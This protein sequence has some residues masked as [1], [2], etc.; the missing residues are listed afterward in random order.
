MP[1]IGQMVSVSYNAVLA[2]Q[3]KPANQW[4]ESALMR[5]FESGG[6]IKRMDFGPQI[7]APLDYQR[8]PG[9][10]ITTVDLQPLSNT[11]TET[12]T[13]ALYTPAEVVIPITYSD[14]D[15]VQN[16][17]SNQKVAKA[18]ALITNALDS[19]D[20][21]VE[22]YLFPAS[23]NGFLGFLTHIT[24]AGTGSSG[25]ISATT[26]A[27]WRNQQATYIDDTDIEAAFTTVYNSC[28][29]G[30]GSKTQPT[31]MVSDSPTHATFVGTQ[32]ALQ[33]WGA[34]DKLNAGFSGGIKFMNADYIFSQY[35]G[36]SVQFLNPKSFQ[37]CVSKGHFRELNEQIP[38]ENATGYTRRVYSALQTVVSNRSR[39]G[40]A[41][42]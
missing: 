39:L 24:L 41:H 13:S 19:H 8:N 1:T 10:V 40:V 34:G 42:L 23:T 27:F 35:G 20:D 12:I 15:E 7:E 29:K 31:L 26:D 5:A 30:S 11:K 9:S 6:F 3:R 33:R 2:D 25:G 22:Q 38:L 4:A 28:M 17:T 14:M 32:Q 37:L 18:A 21:L 36:T 16:P